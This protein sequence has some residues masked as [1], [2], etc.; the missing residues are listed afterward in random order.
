MLTQ[1]RGANRTPVRIDRW[2]IEMEPL[3]RWLVIVLLMALTALSVSWV[4]A[5]F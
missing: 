1:V 5:T 4:C 3:T 2:L